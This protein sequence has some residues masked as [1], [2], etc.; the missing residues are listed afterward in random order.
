[1][2]IFWWESSNEANETTSIKLG[3]GRVP[4][5]EI[6]E[7]S[8]VNW[9]RPTTELGQKGHFYAGTH[10]DGLYLASDQQMKGLGGV[11]L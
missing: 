7:G 3:I 11:G 1:M 6:D 4:V 10:G 5:N 9:R 2:H 8:P